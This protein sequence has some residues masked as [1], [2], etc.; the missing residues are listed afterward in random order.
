MS[1]DKSYF[2]TGVRMGRIDDHKLRGLPLGILEYLICGYCLLSTGNYDFQVLRQEFQGKYRTCYTVQA[3][4]FLSF[5]W[6]YTRVVSNRDTVKRRIFLKSCT[7][8]V[9]YSATERA[10]VKIQRVLIAVS[11]FD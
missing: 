5:L 1:A 4:F 7:F 10:S 2:L 9:K 3:F 6:Y 8:D 11:S